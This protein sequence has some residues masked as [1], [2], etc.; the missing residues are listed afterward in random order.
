MPD[1]STMAS[2]AAGWT[3]SHT[4]SGSG[5][6]KVIFKTENKFVDQDINVTITTPAAGA[7]SLAADDNSAGLTWGTASGGV[8]SPTATITGNISAASAGWI[9]GANYNVTDTGV[10]V[11][12]VNQSTM[13]NGATPI[14]TGAE[15]VPSSSDQTITISEG[16]NGQRTIVVKAA[17]SADPATVTSGSARIETISSYTYNSSGDNAG[18]FTLAGTANVSAPTVG[19]AGYI[20]NNIGTLNANNGGAVLSAQVNKISIKATLSGTTGTLT[21][22]IGTTSTPNGVT[23]A[24]KTG[25]SASTTAPTTGVYV[26]VQSAENS[27]TITATPGVQVAGYGTT[28]SGQYTVYSAPST[29]VGAA[30]SAVTYI[31]IQTTSASVSGNTVTYGSGWITGGTSTVAA[32]T[33]TSGSVTATLTGPTYNSGTGKF[34]IAASGT[35]P[36]PI[37]NTE[38][39]IS[40]TIGT[41]NTGSV[42][43]STSLNKVKV[44]VTVTGTETVTPVIARTPKPNGDTWEDAAY[45]TGTDGNSATTTKPTSSSN[46]AYVAVDAAALTNTLT[47]TGKVTEA[48]Y[49]TTTSGQ[50]TT[51][52]A[53]TKSVGSTAADRTYIPIK[54]GTV[55]SGT[56]NITSVTYTYNSGTGTFNV[57]GSANIPAPTV[58]TAGYVSSNYGTK[59]GATGGATVTTTVNK[60]GIQANLSG[61]GTKQPT[62]SKH[63]DTNVVSGDRTTTK[64][65]SGYYV[66]VNSAANTGTVKATATVVSAGYGTT[67]AGQYNTTD[68]SNLTIGA[69]ASETTYIPIMATTFANSGTSG[70]TYTDISSSAPVLISGDYLYINAGYT[71]DVKI[72]LAKLV[73]DGENTGTTASSNSMLSGFTAYNY[74]GV[75]ITGTIQTYTGIYE[76]V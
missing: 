67:T 11:G 13:A 45:N 56:A 27:G 5:D 14:T 41:R 73:P 25:G 57:A 33:V 55:V 24:L 66:A 26:A 8:Y 42:N 7:I 22:T 53:T 70:T 21:P 39:Y 38:G 61:T 43:G 62:I 63:S 31:P 16:Y 30:Q 3:H 36:I 10:V 12:T 28:T 6:Y 50:Y 2:G 1:E 46:Y 52:A 60:I 49:G 40:E 47:I 37:V 44:G 74:D 23:N 19:T 18:K 34:D 65:S 48:G 68:S 4:T 20:S 35:V 59:T 69:S 15:I 64:P 72:S 76:E 9:T 29:T 54:N 58:T 17:S 75:R 71:P 32:G 51:D